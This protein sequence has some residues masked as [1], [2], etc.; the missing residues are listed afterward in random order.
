MQGKMKKIPRQVVEVRREG[1][2]KV[3]ETDE[4]EIKFSNLANKNVQQTWSF[5]TALHEPT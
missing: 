3:A 5:G 2:K 4:T 1:E